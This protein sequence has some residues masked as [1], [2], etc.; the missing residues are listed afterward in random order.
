VAVPIN[1]TQALP[2]KTCKEVTIDIELSAGF[3]EEENIPLASILQEAGAIVF[4]GVMGYKTHTKMVLIVR[5][6]NGR[7]K[8]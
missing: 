1:N 4:C 2:Q 7:L 6:E 3:D 5:R 8:R